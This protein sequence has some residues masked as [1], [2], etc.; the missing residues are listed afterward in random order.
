MQIDMHCHTA[1]GSVDGRVSIFD[2]VDQLKLKG[3][4]AVLTTDHNSYRGYEAWQESG[5]DDFIVFKGIEYDTLDAG[6]MIIIMPDEVD[7]KVF[8]Y[9]G[10][11]V[12]RLIALVHR[13]GGLIG[14]AHPYDYCK[15][16]MQ[17]HRKW[18]KMQKICHEFDFIEAF[19]SCASV[20][21][22]HLA[23]R[24]TK[25]YKKPAFGGSDNH[26]FS[27]IGLGSTYL[28]AHPKNNSQLIQ[29]IKH[30]VSCQAGGQYNP[31]SFACAHSFLY[32]CGANLYY[33]TSNKSL[34]LIMAYKR[35]KAQKGTI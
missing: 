9:R 29:A 24:L 28:G 22:N 10:M 13:L 31:D 3:Y 27:G 33:Y 15:F 25:K 19:N 4:Q 16:G 21:G 1:E 30:G 18:R 34:A 12:K 7:T 5:R 17:N 6:H 23:A 20:V 14:P 11:D 35:N 8:S 2:I 32:S 26:R